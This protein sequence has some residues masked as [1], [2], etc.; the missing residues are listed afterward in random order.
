MSR[1][2]FFLIA[3]VWHSVPNNIR[4]TEKIY[5]R[6]DQQDLHQL[7]KFLVRCA[8]HWGSKTTNYP[9]MEN[10]TGIINGTGI[11]TTG[12]SMYDG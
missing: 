8:H 5:L 1:L 4:I 11:G 6:K 2:A 9:C 7:N 3:R 12:N 10:D